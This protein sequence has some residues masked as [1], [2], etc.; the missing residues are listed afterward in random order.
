MPVILTNN[1]VI[2]SV[3]LG[4][5]RPIPEQL[6]WRQ[7]AG[8]HARP[9]GGVTQRSILVRIHLSLPEALE[10]AEKPHIKWTQRVKS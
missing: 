10:E 4:S 5:A 2:H 9:H 8:C 7:A 6:C 1:F 3:C